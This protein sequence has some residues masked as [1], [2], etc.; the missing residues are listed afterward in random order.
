[1]GLD[2]LIVGKENIDFVGFDVFIGIGATKLVFPHKVF[3]N[4][5]IGDA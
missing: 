5:L 3:G 4:D 2:V 1:V